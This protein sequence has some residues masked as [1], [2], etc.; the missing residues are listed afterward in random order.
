ML[1]VHVIDFLFLRQCFTRL[2]K[3]VH[4]FVAIRGTGVQHRIS[5]R[6][7]HLTFARALLEH[8]AHRARWRRQL[9][10]RAL[11][12][13]IAQ[14]GQQLRHRALQGIIVQAPRHLYFVLQVS[15]SGIRVRL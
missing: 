5:L 7:C 1:A 2:R 6:L 11:Q 9:P 8:I 12:G 14:R 10:G 13:L 4:R 15:S 3:L